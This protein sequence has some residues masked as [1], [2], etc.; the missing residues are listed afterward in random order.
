MTDDTTPANP[1]AAPVSF[2]EIARIEAEAFKRG[3]E[4]GKKE[5][6]PVSDEGAVRAFLS[7]EYNKEATTPA[8][9]AR[10][11]EIGALLDSFDRKPA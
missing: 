1:A 4:A 3:L 11:R 9:I 5:T 7:R 8:Q 6:A 10:Q 2:A